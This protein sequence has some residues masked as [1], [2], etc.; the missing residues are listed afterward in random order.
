MPH[1]P[2]LYSAVQ[3]AQ[4]F[5][6]E[7]RELG[8][9]HQRGARCGR[10]TSRWANGET[11]LPYGASTRAF[12]GFGMHSFVHSAFRRKVPAVLGVVAL[13]LTFAAPVGGA[14]GA[15]ACLVKN[16]TLHA[17]YNG[18][19]GSI[20]QTAINEAG[21]GNTLEVRGRCVGNFLINNKSLTVVGIA[22]HHYPVATL[23]GNASGSV[24]S[25][26][27]SGVVTLRDIL[28]TGGTALG[29]YNNGGFVTLSGATRVEGNTGGG[30]I[31]NID[32]GVTLNDSAR[33]NGNTA[34]GSDFSIGGG[35]YN[36]RGLVTL[37]GSA[38]VND[39]TAIGAPSFYGGGGIMNDQGV[40]TLN[41]SAQVNGNTTSGSG[42][43][44]YNFPG[45]FGG[46]VTLNDSAQVNGN[47]ASGP[48]GGIYNAGGTVTLNDSSTVSGNVPDDC[49]ACQ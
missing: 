3:E 25:L 8:I 45:A 28:I 7:G 24:V 49:F 13:S 21:S 16:T 30:G 29:I 41:D 26:T 4:D 1:R 38:Q 12:G 22:T 11:D 39:N 32:G 27:F 36:H 10:L 31:A 33:V 44:I 18:A 46:V 40:V 43:G 14:A 5:K 6:W 2:V 34:S 9:S 19:S 23:D 20:L 47:T 48:G 15:K 42:G 17:S 37:N 35:I